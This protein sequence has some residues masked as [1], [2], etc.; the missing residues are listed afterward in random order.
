[1]W[2]EILES[3]RGKEKHKWGKKGVESDRSSG[4]ER[5]RGEDRKRNPAEDGRSN[6]IHL[7]PLEQTLLLPGLQLV[8][9]AS[10]PTLHL[11]I[12][13]FVNTTFSSPR[14][15]RLAEG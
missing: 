3:R 11:Q 12:V 10:P 4:E 15:N 2:G 5:R 7:I 8:L 13:S 14:Y 1:M 9:G 6:F